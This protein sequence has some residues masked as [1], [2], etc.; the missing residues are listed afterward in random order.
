MK[1][2]TTLFLVFASAAFGIE[3]PGYEV[4]R[5]NGKIELRKYE[6]LPV[7]SAPMAGMNQRNDS[8][9]QLFQYISGANAK[10]QK[11]KMTA[12]V[13]MEGS[14]KDRAPAKSGTMSFL[15][16]SKVAMAGSPDPSGDGVNLGKINGGTIAAIRFKGWKSEAARKAAIDDLQDWVKSQ[17][18]KADGQPFFAIYNPPWTPEFMRRNEVWLRVKPT[19]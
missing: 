5:K 18:W 19:R 13:F 9:G 7:V 10:Q 16:P 14:H 3:K 1:I 12:P 6:D 8:F 2:L 17:G 15:I 4:L 11:I